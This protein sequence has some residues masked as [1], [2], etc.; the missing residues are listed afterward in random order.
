MSEQS[1]FKDRLAGLTEEE[2]WLKNNIV[3]GQKYDLEPG[4][5]CHRCESWTGGDK[6][7]DCGRT[8]I[9]PHVDYGYDYQQEPELA[10]AAGAPADWVMEEIFRDAEERM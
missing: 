4:A 9:Y 6:M 3:I 5:L 8:P 2:I 10:F 1:D 7:C